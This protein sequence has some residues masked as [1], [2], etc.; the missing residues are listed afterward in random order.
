MASPIGYENSTA[1]M[2]IVI[3]I[4]SIDP[5]SIEVLSGVSK[6]EAEISISVVVSATAITVHANQVDK[7]HS[8]LLLV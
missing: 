4:V 8:L 7:V 6:V 1:K 5:G 3:L 2:V